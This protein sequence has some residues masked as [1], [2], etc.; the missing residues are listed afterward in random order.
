MI[1]AHRAAVHAAIEAQGVTPYAPGK[2]PGDAGL[3]GEPAMPYAVPYID[4]GS[5]SSYRMSSQSDNLRFRVV[6]RYW[7]VNTDQAEWAAERVDA[8]L[9]DVSLTVAGRDCTPCRL[10]SSQDVGLD[11]TDDPHLYG[12]SSTWTFAST[13]A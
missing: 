4:T 9:A 3:P 5:R 1:R 2:L 11:D 12:G 13:P 10:E 7:G 8:A 6:V